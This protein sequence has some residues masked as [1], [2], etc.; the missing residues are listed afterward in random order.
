M[1]ILPQLGGGTLQNDLATRTAFSIPAMRLLALPMGWMTD[2]FYLPGTSYSRRPHDYT[3][4]D[5]LFH[6]RANGSL[7]LSIPL[8]FAPVVP[9]L[10]SKC[11][12]TAWQYLILVTFPQTRA[13]V[14]IVM[15][16]LPWRSLLADT[17]TMESLQQYLGRKADRD[18]PNC[19][20]LPS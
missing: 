1:V 17:G 11:L 7:P 3:Q 16:L 13:T 14:C 15:P 6:H 8:S 20:C 5:T 10:S 19:R 4:A 18:N 9:F 2:F 12:D